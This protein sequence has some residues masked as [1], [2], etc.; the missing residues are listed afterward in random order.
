LRSD[1]QY[2]M[3]LELFIPASTTRL[4]VFILRLLRSN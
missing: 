1:R 4:I 2:F 3:A